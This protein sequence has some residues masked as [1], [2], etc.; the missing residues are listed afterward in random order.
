MRCQ[1]DVLVLVESGWYRFSPVF[2]GLIWFWLQRWGTL[3]Q[4]EAQVGPHSGVFLARKLTIDSA[5]VV[6]LLFGTLGV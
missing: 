5:G 1:R 6:S 3:F 2:F 4:S